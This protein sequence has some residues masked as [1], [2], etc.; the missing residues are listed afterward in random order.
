M[1]DC[2][3]FVWL[4][5]IYDSQPTNALT[6]IDVEIQENC[7]ESKDSL[8]QGAKGSYRYLLPLSA[9]S[10]NKIY[11]MNLLRLNSKIGG[12]PAGYDGCTR[13]INGGREGTCLYIIWKSQSVEPTS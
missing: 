11:S 3:R 10:G 5:P 2:I 6:S 7:D 13:N 9:K 4:V 12:A 8:A 1:S